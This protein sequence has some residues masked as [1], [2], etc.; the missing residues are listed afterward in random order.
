MAFPC[1]GSTKR[2]LK[3][4]ALA[5]FVAP[6]IASASVEAARSTIISVVLPLAGAVVLLAA[7]VVPSPEMVVSPLEAVE[8]PLQEATKRINAKKSTL[9]IIKESILCITQVPKL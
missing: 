6:L 7:R 3:D 5:T 2:P 8:L 1:G 4:G 9:L